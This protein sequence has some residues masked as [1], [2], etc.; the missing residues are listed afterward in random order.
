MLPGNS[1]L[2]TDDSTDNLI[3][4]TFI[5]ADIHS[6]RAV[7]Y[8]FEDL[9]F[10]HYLSLNII[11]SQIALICTA[12]LSTWLVCYLLMTEL[13]YIFMELNVYIEHLLVALLSPTEDSMEVTN[14]CLQHLLSSSLWCK[15]L[16]LVIALANILV[17]T[18]K[19][20]L[21][22]LCS[23]IICRHFTM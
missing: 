21:L 18:M 1:L 13:K 22:L 11:F 5:D 7:I 2:S 4:I 12:L 16:L 23:Y 15:H 9:K 19:T 8:K 10:L 20:K 17:I 6:Y 14:L 3:L